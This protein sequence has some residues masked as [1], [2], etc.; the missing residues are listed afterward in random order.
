MAALQ[1]PPGLRIN[2]NHNVEQD[3][4]AVIQPRIR[5][6]HLL[7]RARKSRGGSLDASA[8]RKEIGHATVMVACAR[9]RLSRRRVAQQAAVL[10]RWYNLSGEW[11]EMVKTWKGR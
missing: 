6:L 2:L 4:H 5:N 3:D 8:L 9:Q 7:P 1:Y 10:A 11:S